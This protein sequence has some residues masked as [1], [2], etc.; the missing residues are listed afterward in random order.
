MMR[1]TERRSMRFRAQ[2]VE[3]L[4]AGAA[5]GFEDAVLED[6]RAAFPELFASRGAGSARALVREGRARAQGHGFSLKAQV[7]EYVG[8][9]FMLGARFD[10]D[11]SLP[12]A[13]KILAD[14][15]PA[16]PALRI[17]RL[18]A[19]ARAHLRGLVMRGKR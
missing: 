16:D 11:E 18:S 12:W 3:A 6:L 17:E 7:A 13:A 2:Q 9:A 19:A 1:A 4:A 5:A 8:L 14:P 10:E 15:A